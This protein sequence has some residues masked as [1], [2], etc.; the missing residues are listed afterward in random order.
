MPYKKIG[1]N[2]YR[3]KDGRTLTLAQI[4]AYYANKKKK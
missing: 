2:K 1:K 3:A 4:R